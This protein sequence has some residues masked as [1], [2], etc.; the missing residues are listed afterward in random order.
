MA[1]NDGYGFQTIS[2]SAK[3][4]AKLKTMADKES[5]SLAN[6]VGVCVENEWN[7]RQGKRL[8]ALHR[9]GETVVD[10]SFEQSIKPV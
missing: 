3:H 4:Y 6:M 9:N 2:I 10:P 7:S 1:R 8:V 5:R